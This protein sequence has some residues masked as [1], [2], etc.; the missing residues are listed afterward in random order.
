M[1]LVFTINTN[2]VSGWRNM[3][4]DLY[5]NDV[6]K[7]SS[8]SIYH[9]DVIRLESDG[10]SYIDYFY[11]R[12]PIDEME[13]FMDIATDKLSGVLNVPSSGSYSLR[14]NIVKIIGIRVA[15]YQIERWETNNFYLQVDGVR[16]TESGFYVGDVYEFATIGNYVFEYIGTYNVIFETWD[17]FELSDDFRVATI[18]NPEFSDQDL[19]FKIELGP[20][21]DVSVRGANTV[22]RVTDEA[23]KEITH[24]RFDYPTSSS[25]IEDFGQFILGLIEL[26][27]EVDEDFVVGTEQVQLGRL[28][29]GVMG[30]VLS[31][32]RMQFDLGEIM[33]V[34]E[35]SDARDYQDVEV[36]LHLPFAESLGIEPEYVVNQTIGIVLSVSLY[37]GTADY[38]IS[39]TFA[40]GWALSQKVSLEIDVPFANVDSVPGRNNPSNMAF[41]IDN[42]ILTAYVEVKRPE[43]LLVGSRFSAPALAEELIGMQSGYVVVDEIRLD[44]GCTSAEADMLKSILKGGVIIDM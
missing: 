28:R 32:D 11:L 22:F 18:P 2:T 40:N 12:D 21:V 31:R 14:Q 8:V 42:G 43:A 27:F 35:F 15:D 17:Y 3:G 24:K 9:D 4:M 37:D 7:I 1:A 23:M 39:S 25:N 41:G 36:I 16:I 30:E 5:V 34:G 10:R 19:R 20:D 29:T 13:V 44:V 6:K 26:P 33:V 38:M